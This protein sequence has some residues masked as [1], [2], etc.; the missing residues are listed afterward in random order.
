[1]SSDTK[2][3]EQSLIHDV[4]SRNFNEMVETFGDEYMARK[5]A[6]RMVWLLK[7]IEIFEGHDLERYLSIYEGIS[8]YGL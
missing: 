2:S 6:N 5:V 7:D 8:D 1:M 4:I 3:S